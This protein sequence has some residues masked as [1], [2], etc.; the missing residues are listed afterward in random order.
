MVCG[1]TVV[2][3]SPQNEVSKEIRDMWD[4]TRRDLQ[5]NGD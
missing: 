5:L 1:K 3:Y 4:I 2:E